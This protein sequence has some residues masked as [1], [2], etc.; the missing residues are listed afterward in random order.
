M[1]LQHSIQPL[2]PSSLLFESLH[3]TDIYLLNACMHLSLKEMLSLL[4]YDLADPATWKV[5]HAL[6]P[7]ITVPTRTLMYDSVTFNSLVF[8]Q[9]RMNLNISISHFD[10]SQCLYTALLLLFQFKE[11]TLKFYFKRTENR[12]TAQISLQTKPS[13]GCFLGI[14]IYPTL[15]PCTECDTR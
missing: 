10:I 13:V 15:L 9:A 6:L 1:I 12:S 2:G 8:L 7:Y 4:S 11:I 5:T 14:S 3:P